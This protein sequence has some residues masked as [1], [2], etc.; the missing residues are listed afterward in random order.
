M[1]DDFSSVFWSKTGIPA[2]SQPPLSDDIDCD[3]VIVGAGFTGLRASV[4]LAE[5]GA[6]VVVLD[7]GDVG[8]GAS[9]RSGGQVNPMLP[10]VGPDQLFQAVGT[11]Y[12]ERLISTSLGSADELFD[13]IRTYEIDC[14]ARQQGWLR[15]DHCARAKAV[16]RKNAKGWIKFGAQVQFL[17]GAE[18]TNLTGTSAYD[19]G[20][21]VAKGGAVQPLSLVRGMAKV[22]QSKG[23]E[24][25]GRSA[26]TRLS[27][28][29]KGW[30][31][32]ANDHRINC[33]WVILA[34]NGYTDSLLPGLSKS[35][36]VL[37][38]IQIATDSLDVSLIANILPGGH[39]ISDT[40]RIIMYA[41]REPGD[42]IVFG[43]IGKR[44]SNGQI[45]GYENLIKDAVRIYPALR[46]VR[47]TFKWGGNIALTAD[48]LPHF[49][50]PAKG[51]IAGLGFNGRGVAMAHVMGR[52]LAERALGA[53]PKTLPFPVTQITK[54][55]FRGVSTLGQSA[56]VRCMSLL[57][58]IEFRLW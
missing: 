1:I 24:I 28:N 9:G 8:W 7:T 21:L 32:H 22:S 16:S 37:V 54:Y 17:E 42:Q 55:P 53:D 26:V 31:V 23:T 14:Q 40:R 35:L 11:N 48:H 19:S 43:G 47:W 25:Y 12:F 50:E 4:R 56:A 18:L 34:T 29:A 30:T 41:R 51:L 38:P 49:H 45:S 52:V 2:H 20:V 57:D 6:K 46:D 15:V 3:V 44:G 5:S 58:R 13:L 39:T 36:F 27:Q 33:E 10:F